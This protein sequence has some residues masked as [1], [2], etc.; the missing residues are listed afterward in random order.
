MTA[1]SA[2]KKSKDAE[3]MKKLREDVLL[4]LWRTLRML[5]MAM[6][7]HLY[8]RLMMYL[9]LIKIEGDVLSLRMMRKTITASQM[10]KTIWTKMIL[11]VKVLDML[12][13]PNSGQPSVHTTSKMA[14]A[15]QGDVNVL[16]PPNVATSVAPS[17]KKTCVVL[18]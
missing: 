11:N 13:T 15:H 5:Q 18:S 10:M 2:K 3:T 9:N 8:L 4:D 6:I 7:N 16:N 12:V 17:M 1:V 14:A